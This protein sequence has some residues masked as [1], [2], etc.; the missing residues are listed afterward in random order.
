[1]M[2]RRDNKT[3]DLLNWTPP[4]VVQ[5]FEDRRVR[6]VEISAQLSRGVAATLADAEQDRK[7]I[8]AQ[9]SAWLGEPVSKD[10]L[11]QYASQAKAGHVISLPRA[12]ALMLAAGDVRLL[13]L[14]ADLLGH[15]VIPAKYLAAVEDAMTADQIE[16]LRRRQRD[17]RATWKGGK[18]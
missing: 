14:M 17:L 11:D 16:S 10:M 12:L 5:R 9:M 4:A 7:E 8:A 3:L 1:M 2:P 18:P 13:Q 6:A 15:A